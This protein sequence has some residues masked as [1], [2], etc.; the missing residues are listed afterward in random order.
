M[1][2][3]KTKCEE[4]KNTTVSKSR[5]KAAGLKSAFAVNGDVLLTSFGRGNDAV[6]EKLI[7]EEAVSE[8]NTGKPKFTVE[9]PATSH[10]SSFGIKSHI[11]AKA[12]NPL[13][14]R[15]AN[16]GED[17]LHAKEALEKR[18]FGRAFPEDN[19]HIQLIYNILDIRKI[20]SIYANNV[21]FTINSLRRLDEYDR[22]Q[23]YLGYLYTGN[24][25]DRL[26]DIA[27][28][29]TVDDENWKTT[30]AGIANDFE[31]KQ[32]QTIN[33]FW[34]LLD[35]IEPYMCYFSEAFYCE[36]S[37]KDPE[38]GRK[39][40]CLKQRSDKDIY[41]ILRILSI[42][43]QICMHDNASMRTIMYTLGQNPEIERKNG[44]DELTDLL[45]KLY[46]EK[47]VIVN[48][49]F[50]RNQKNNIE[51]LSRIYGYTPD[52]PERN[53]L[54][55]DFYD[56]KVLSQDK[57]LG[58]SIK[59]LR[60]KLLDAPKL[61][62]VRDKKYDT[63][64]SKLYSLIDF[65]L[66]RKFSN[67]HAAVESFV[68]E[69]RSLL[70]ED[71]KEN[72]YVRQAEK[73]I[74]DGFAQEIFGKMLPQIDPKAIGKIKGSRLSDDNISGIRLNANASYFTKILNVVCMFLDGKEI[75][76]LVSAL[77]NKFSNIQSFVDVMRSQNIDC[78]FTRDYAIFAE[79]GRISR[80]LH[81]LKGIAR[82][83]RSIAGLG[84]VK[85]LGS[86]D[87]LHGVSR[88]VYTD[89]AYILGFGERSE[90]N[91]GYVDDYVSS[92]LLGGAD[93]NLRNFITNNVIKNRRFL[94][95]VRYM[96]PKRA[97][98][99]VQ[100]SA[101]VEMVLR[102]IPETQ[103]D[104]YYK[105]CI[106]KK[107]FNPGL[108]EKTA[109][110]SEMITTLKIDDFEDVKQSPDK[111][112]EYD[113][114]KQ[115]RTSKERYK[116]CIGLYLT[117]LYLICKNL[118]KINARYSIA[119]GCLERDTQLHG[120]NSYSAAY[121]TRDVF[122]ANGWINSKKP[123][124]KSMK[125]QYSYLTP[126]IFT[127]Y[128]NQIAHLAAVTNAYKYIPKM[129][130]VKSYFHLYHTVIQHSILQQYEHDKNYGRKG[131]PAVS[132]RVLGLLEQCREH[133]NYSRD[134]LRILNLPFGYNL[135]RFL[136]LSSEKFFE[137]NEI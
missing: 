51:I 95:T 45:D 101:L 3:I 75:N 20:L 64:R 92:K 38:S 93:K 17:A 121:M 65:M 127:T 81:V 116:A 56:F 7:T 135:P 131:A 76:E 1:T 21:V 54:V 109:A 23:D 27:D 71:E 61:F 33:G 84:D 99:L 106:E 82:M 50:L 73:L 110:L 94:Y 12:D 120:V 29:Y 31:K 57:N 34:D 5:S 74:R 133:N 102:D 69:L 90:D 47:I 18:V 26:W 100:N 10:S 118:V 128:R 107:T 115:Q 24:S 2:E 44:Y 124:V 97:K 59:K 91:D 30:A 14:G 46:N 39:T 79:S 16:V 53:R 25:F 87:K 72:A 13:A 125:E 126:Y 123:A 66:Y 32:F 86:D 58:F 68:E 117:V 9:K 62:K 104:R 55:Q 105:S 113:V 48:R 11:T 6:P 122:I 111:N 136:N 42:V 63:M 41:N 43:R 35:M 98:K 36:A 96:N 28:R 37:V 80:E 49:D 60:E 77:V 88:R 19:I 129:D 89:A 85:I 78:G 15:R 134:L 130:K 119:I 22:E 8:L 137:A 67:D 103:I 4:A 112:A 52:S 132:E 108:Y 83:Q 40:A 114:K 70:T